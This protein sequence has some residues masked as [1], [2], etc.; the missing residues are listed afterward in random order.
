MSVL[1]EKPPEHEENPQYGLKGVF[2][3]PRM[4]KEFLVQQCKEHKLYRTP[5]LND[6]LYLHFKGFSYIENLEEYTGLKCL[7]LE[8]N[9]I[10]KISGL[11][12]QK[13]LRSLFLHYNLIR[14]IENLENCPI[15]DNLNL[16]HNQ[17]KKIENLDCIKQLHSLNLSH[18][19]I[20]IIEDLEHLAQLLELSVLDLSNNHIEN[21]LVVEILGKMP[22][23]RVLNLMGNP[24]IR[25][26]PAYRKTM[27]LACKNLRYLDDRPVFPRDRACAEAWGRG[28][29]AEEN[30]ERQRWIEREQ[31]KITESVDALI[32]MRD[33]RRAEMARQ[34]SHSD[35][36]VGASVADSESE[37]KGEESSDDDDE[38]EAE[39]NFMQERQTSEDYSAYRERIF[40]FDPRVARERKLLVEEIKED[41]ECGGGS[42]EKVDN[43]V[44]KTDHNLDAT[45]LQELLQEVEKKGDDEDLTECFKNMMA[46]EYLEEN[47]GKREE[48][49]I[50]SDVEQE[51]TEKITEEVGK[52]DI[53]KEENEDVIGG[54]EQSRMATEDK[55]N[56]GAD[57]LQKEKEKNMSGMEDDIERS[58]TENKSLMTDND[59][60]ISNEMEERTEEN[61]GLPE[62]EV[63]K[64]ISDEDKIE[65]TEE[66]LNDALKIA[67]SEDDVGVESEENKNLGETFGSGEEKRNTSE[68]IES[69]GRKLVAAVDKIAK[70]INSNIPKNEDDVSEVNVEDKEVNEACEER[71]TEKVED[72]DN[73]GRRLVEAVDKMANELNCKNEEKHV[74]SVDVPENKIIE[75]GCKED[76]TNKGN[77]DENS[78]GRKLVEAINNMSRETEG[79]SEDEEKCYYEEL[80]TSTST[81]FDHL[82]DRNDGHVRLQTLD[83][84]ITKEDMPRPLYVEEIDRANPDRNYREI[85]DWKLKIKEENTRILLPIKRRIQV[86]EDDELYELIE[87]MK[88]DRDFSVMSPKYIDENDVVL[89]PSKIRELSSG[90]ESDDDEE[91]NCGMIA[92]SI[93]NLRKDM[94]TFCESIE[95]FIKKTK[96]RGKGEDLEEKKE[97]KSE[98]EVENIIKKDHTNKDGQTPVE[99]EDIKIVKLRGR[100]KNEDLDA[101]GDDEQV[102][103]L[104]EEVKLTEKRTEKQDVDKKIINTEDHA[105]EDKEDEDK[106]NKKE[107][108]LI[109]GRRRALEEKVEANEDFADEHK[110][111]PAIDEGMEQIKLTGEIEV[112]EEKQN[113]NEKK[114]EDHTDEEKQVPLTDKMSEREEGGDLVDGKA[115]EIVTGSED[116]ID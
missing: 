79:D 99:D 26:I 1:A 66:N 63:S 10:R 59:V 98:I 93:A 83:R 12:N 101:N 7:W 44:N 49:L 18:N 19:Y 64:K 65:D 15:L 35:S 86:D 2:K 21:P 17:V 23:L 67:R 14:K 41:E 68:D 73:L 40:D 82:L 53:C 61:D 84:V 54:N 91:D 104:D 111:V 8:N 43:R 109:R 95:E 74:C 106:D 28:G 72:F 92:R 47:E 78:L 16:S 38:E 60:I 25:K 22:E 31:R 24:V 88:K 46:I 102:S 107:M 6:V 33:R 70:E 20:E 105:D 71:S 62:G 52:E 112:L 4:T 51:E 90:E 87:E 42:E 97:V 100:R 94:A 57:G 9:G 77:E 45:K 85:L 56:V 29:I 13:Q 48:N 116:G 39:D 32:R 114:S 81:E 113:I 11:D 27:I 96:M 55:K 3:S 36:G 108:E 80:D 103:V 5:H 34:M 76:A 30:A 110:E 75:E 50:N 89:R 37:D 69:L 115:Q 58:T